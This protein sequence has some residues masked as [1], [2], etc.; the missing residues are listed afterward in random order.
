M[1]IMENVG[2]L[3]K[4]NKTKTK[5]LKTMVTLPGFMLNLKPLKFLLSDT[6]KLPL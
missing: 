5:P 4:P 3:T 2:S 1:E 6:N